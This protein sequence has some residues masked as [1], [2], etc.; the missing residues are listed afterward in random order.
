MGLCQLSGAGEGVGSGQW[1][2]IRR[3][4]LAR[5]E[6]ARGLGKCR[7]PPADGRGPPKGVASP[8]CLNAQSDAARL[9]FWGSKHQKTNRP[10]PHPEA[11]HCPPSPSRRRM[12]NH[13][14]DALS[15][16]QHRLLRRKIETLQAL[17]DE[18]DRQ[19]AQ[20]NEQLHFLKGL[21]HQLDGA[22]C[23]LSLAHP[24]PAAPRPDWPRGPNGRRPQGPGD[25]GPLGAA[26]MGSVEMAPYIAEAAR[27]FGVPEQTIR[28]ELHGFAGPAPR[29]ELRPEA[30]APAVVGGEVSRA[31]GAALSSVLSFLCVPHRVDVVQLR[32]RDSVPPAV[33]G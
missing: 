31:A 8:A 12:G 21:Q 4:P 2:P 27:H 24:W 32:L 22:R 13:I 16:L 3:L 7:E 15:Q 33:E 11:A 6:L 29:P 1:Y 19:L 14:E 30:P 18:R 20:Q 5:A 28:R 9:F 26:L 23:R 17:L 10:G 25:V